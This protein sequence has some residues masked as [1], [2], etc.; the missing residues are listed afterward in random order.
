MCTQNAGLFLQAVEETALFSKTFAGSL[1]TVR[2]ASFRDEVLAV[3]SAAP[4]RARMAVSG[5][6]PVLESAHFT[7]LVS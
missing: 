1:W 7:G 2:T 4:C 3:C 6:F 5:N